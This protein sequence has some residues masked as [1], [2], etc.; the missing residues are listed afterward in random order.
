MKNSTRLPS[1]LSLD[2]DEEIGRIIVAVARDAGFDAHTTGTAAAF[3]EQLKLLEPDVIVLDL[4]IPD[5]DGVQLLRELADRNPKCSIVFVT[6]MDS[7]TIA[8]TEHYAIT[9]GL[10]VCGSVQKPFL[11]EDLLRTLVSVRSVTQPL[12]P[13]DFERAMRN[14][15]LIVHYQPVLKRFADGWSIDSVE[16]LLRWEHPERGT[17]LPRSFLKL[18]DES[19]LNRDMT[20]FVLQRALEQ[21]KGWRTAGLD[22]RLRVNLS[23]GLISDIEFPDRLA[24]ALEHHGHDGSALILEVNETAMLEENSTTIDILTRLRLKEI[25]LAIDDFGVGYSSLT[26]LF[27]LPFSEMKIDRSL[28]ARIPDS[29]ETRISV[30]ALIDLAHKLSLEVCGEGVETQTALDFLEEA[31]CDSAQGYLICPPVSH[32]EIP[33]VIR[34]WEEKA[35][36]FSD[37]QRQRLRQ[38]GLE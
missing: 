16:A 25:A 5:R 13:A 20:D 37:Q 21:L 32:L 6:G 18:G 27:R 17:L 11:P 15:Q 36:R 30:E 7:R 19:G 1:L 29:K 28:I 22:L 4:Q 31:R 34:N 12:G 33:A 9:R 23:A 3:L 24:M 14:D 8:S 2:D 26:Q 38:A 35:R 10:Q